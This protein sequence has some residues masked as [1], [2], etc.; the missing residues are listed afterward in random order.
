M[1]KLSKNSDKRPSITDEELRRLYLDERMTSAEIA[2]RV[3]LTRQG[4]SYRLRAAGVPTRTTGARSKRAKNAAKVV[5]LYVDEGKSVDKI[6]REI[7]MARGT[8]SICLDEAGIKRE[9]YR[10]P[11][12]SGKY[13]ELQDLAVGEYIL[14]P[15]PK[16]R[17]KWHGRLYNYAKRYG[18]KI[19]VKVIDDD[20]AKLTRL[21]DDPRK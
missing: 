3:G 11:K 21:P 16:V 19:T 10:Y 13:K 14:I 7:G 20:T 1:T 2:S 18:V 4:V 5:S 8:V 15:R 9:A 17:G 6:A 12:A